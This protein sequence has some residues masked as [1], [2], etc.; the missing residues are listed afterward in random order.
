[1]NVSARMVTHV[2]NFLLVL[3]ATLVQFFYAY[4]IYIL[5]EKSLVFP[6]IIVG[7]HKHKN[8][9]QIN[10]AAGN[11]LA[12]PVGCVAPTYEFSSIA[13][14]LTIRSPW[15]RLYAQS[16]SYTAR[17]KTRGLTAIQSFQVKFFKD[18]KADVVRCRYSM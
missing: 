6:V 10:V 11:L 17:Q 9:S 2:L 14:R 13:H 8:V 3:L 15:D 4:R 7:C 18:A 16:V 12:C 5:S 1:M